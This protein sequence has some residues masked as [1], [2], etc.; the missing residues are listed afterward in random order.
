MEFIKWGLRKVSLG[1]YP[2]VFYGRHGKN[3]Y[4]SIWGGLLSLILYLVLGSAILYRLVSFFK[5]SNYNLI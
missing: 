3:S 5:K 2:T 1:K 4:S